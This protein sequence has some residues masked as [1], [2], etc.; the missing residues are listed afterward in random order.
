MRKLL[1][2][3]LLLVAGFVNAQNIIISNGNSTATALDSAGT[4]TGTAE[5]N[6]NYSYLTI[7]VKSNISSATNGIKVKMG[8]SATTLYTNLLFSYTAGDTTTNRYTVHLTGKYFQVIYVNSATDQTTFDLKTYMHKEEVL[9]LDGTGNIKFDLPNDVNDPLFVSNIPGFRDTLV[10]LNIAAGDSCTQTI[11]FGNRRLKTIYMPVAWTAAN[12][13][14]RVSPDDTTYYNFYADDVEFTSVG[15]A[16]IAINVNPRIFVGIQYLQ[17]RSGT[18]AA[19][20]DQA[21][22]RIIK[23]KIGNY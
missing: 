9:P 20:V 7:V 19:D 11:N 3:I 21:D 8:T 6:T 12:L 13:T 16:G 10:T 17:I 2:I 18:S 1:F 23:L 22:A 4:F 15:A 5:L 14:F